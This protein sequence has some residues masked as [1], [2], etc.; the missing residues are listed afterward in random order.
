MKICKENPHP[1]KPITITL[2]N[3]QDVD[4]LLNFIQWGSRKRPP[5]LKELGNTIAQFIS[6]DAE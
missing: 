5:K 2:E 3:E 6:R 1:F 4:D